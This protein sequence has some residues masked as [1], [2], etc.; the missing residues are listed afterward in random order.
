VQFETSPLRPG[1]YCDD[2]LPDAVRRTEFNGLVLKI[3]RELVVQAHFSR[4][5]AATTARI[6]ALRGDI[7]TSR[8]RMERPRRRPRPRR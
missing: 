1:W 5:L 4:L 3:E 2:V 7:E 6:D 8:R